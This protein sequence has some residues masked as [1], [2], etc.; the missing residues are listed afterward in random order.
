M[1][2]STSP[3]PQKCTNAPTHDIDIVDEF[4]DIIK[5]EEKTRVPKYEKLI[6][7]FIKLHIN[8]SRQRSAEWYDIRKRRI[9]GSEIA[10]LLGMNPYST[11]ADVVATKVGLTTFKGNIACQW[12]TLF[13][14]VIERYVSLDCGTYLQG[15]DVNVP[16]P[17]ESGMY[18]THANSPDGYGVVYTYIENGKWHLENTAKSISTK[19]EKTAI[20]VPSIALFEFKCPF[21]RRPSEDVPPQYLPQVWSGLALSP[22]AHCGI[23]VD[24]VF[25]KCALSKLNNTA[26]YDRNFHKER[27]CDNW[28]TPIAWGFI[29]VTTPLVDIG[30]GQLLA[31]AA[32]HAKFS[33]CG[34]QLL[35]NSPPCIDYGSCSNEQFAEAMNNISS[36]NYKVENFGPCTPDGRHGIHKLTTCEEIEEC[37]NNLRYGSYERSRVG[38]LGVIP[39]KLLEVKYHFVDRCPNFLE[40]IRPYV[41]EV[42]MQVRTCSESADPRD[43][44][45]TMFRVAANH[46]VKESCP[47]PSPSQE[48]E[49]FD[50]VP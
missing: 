27:S 17:K 18:E 39:W 7:E 21:R 44:Y 42:L 11:T 6:E 1:S 22:I 36:G 16:A 4:A 19:N 25:R 9:G 37:I 10:A 50:L 35:I 48:Q 41:E 26:G 33:L 40:K 49:L 12:G 20:L 3:P 43:T 23:F 32:M 31:P 34:E 47:T 5:I 30:N 46:R 38:V 2:A 13:E 45:N 8:R 29:A 28:T 14:S 15:T 24:A